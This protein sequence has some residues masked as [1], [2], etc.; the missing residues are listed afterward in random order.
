MKTKSFQTYL[1]KRLNKDEIAKIKKHA[2]RE[3][4]IFELLQK[5]LADMISDYM[6][7]E[8]IGF[9]EFARTLDASP[10]QVAKMQRGEAN[11]RLSSL[12]HLLAL[13]DAE[14]KDFFKTRK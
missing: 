12:A 7:K 14:P 9:N 8:G 3:I 2:Q 13:I 10:S 5:K 6:K 11:L 4:R 1:E